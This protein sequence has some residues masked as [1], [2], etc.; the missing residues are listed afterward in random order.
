[1]KKTKKIISILTLMAMLISLLP[2][3]VY[4]FSFAEPVGIME[5]G[6][7]EGG[8]PS[9]NKQTLS[10]NANGGTGSM[11]DLIGIIGKPITFPENGF[12]SPYGYI[13]DKWMYS[14]GEEGVYVN[15]NESKIIKFYSFVEVK[16]LW[17]FDPSLPKVTVSYDKNG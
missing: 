4:Q 9:D 7:E 2:I 6:D 15:S 8:G 16:A 10:F 13:F 11:P 12:T 14:E 5:E 1:M 3:N 17:K